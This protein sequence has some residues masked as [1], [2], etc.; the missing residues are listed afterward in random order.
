MLERGREGLDQDGGPDR[1]A[2]EA[3][4]VLGDGERVAPERRLGARLEL[5]EVEERAAAALEQ[6]GGVAVHVQA[7]VHERPGGLLALD[8]QVALREVQP[9]RADEQH[10]VVLVEPVALALLLVLHAPAYGVGEVGLP[11]DHVLPGGRVGVLEVGHEGA[12]AGVQRVDH[13]LAAGGPG[14]LDAA[15]LER[16][17]RGRNVKSAGTSTSRSVPPASSSAW[18]S[19]RARRSRRRVSSSS[20]CRRATSSSAPLVSTCSWR[21]VARPCTS[22]AWW[23]V[24]MLV[25]CPGPARAIRQLRVSRL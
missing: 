10:G 9:A 11:P 25:P 24:L 5:R 13:H 3:E 4:R 1:A 14:D 23:V 2:V 7:E 16:L 18:R 22:M 8:A 19:S 15:V 17:R 6:L 12:R 20:S 21:S